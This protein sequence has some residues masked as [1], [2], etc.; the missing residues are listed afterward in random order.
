MSFYKVVSELT[1]QAP[2]IIL[3]T[4]L[5]PKLREAGVK[6]CQASGR[7]CG[8]K[9]MGCFWAGSGQSAF[10]IVILNSCRSAY[11]PTPAE[12]VS[13]DS[14]AAPARGESFAL[15]LRVLGSFSRIA[16]KA[17]GLS[18]FARQALIKR[19]ARLSSG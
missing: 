13:R 17:D 19:S 4:L 6:A 11:Y 10:R 1:D 12:G 3:R 5:E 9:Q 8:A 16:R 2:E 18:H 7:H 14:A 15:Y